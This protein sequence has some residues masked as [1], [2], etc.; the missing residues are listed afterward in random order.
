MQ[1][2]DEAAH[3][4]ITVYEFPHGLGAEADS[5]FAHLNKFGFTPK[6]QEGT[7]PEA[8]AISLPQHQVP[9]LRE[10]QSQFPTLWGHVPS[11]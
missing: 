10:L 11:E 7:T 8:I 1:A 5:V 3:Q 6:W 9:K 2:I 4:Q